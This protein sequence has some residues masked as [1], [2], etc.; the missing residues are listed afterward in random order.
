M[1]EFY[2]QDAATGIRWDDNLFNIKWH[3]PNNF[4]ISEKDKNYPDFKN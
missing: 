2:N 3:D 4:I 1:N